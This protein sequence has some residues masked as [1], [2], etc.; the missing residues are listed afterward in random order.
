MIEKNKLE[1]NTIKLIK[2]P[3]KNYKKKMKFSIFLLLLLSLLVFSYEKTKQ[4]CSR[5][6]SSCKNNYCSKKTGN[7]YSRCFNDCNNKY[8]VCMKTAK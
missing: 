3:K 4:E 2:N 6:L 5:E 1:K 8:K 7:A